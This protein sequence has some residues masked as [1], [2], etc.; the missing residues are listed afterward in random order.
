MTPKF[1]S[2]YSCEHCHSNDLSYARSINGRF[3]SPSDSYCGFS[4]R[5]KNMR[6]IGKRDRPAGH[7]HPVWCPL[8]EERETCI[9]CGNYI[10]K[11]PSIICP[12]CRRKGL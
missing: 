11:G 9:E 4:G 3:I 5:G 10:Y 2:C 6:R 12:T 8:Y 1:L 7:L